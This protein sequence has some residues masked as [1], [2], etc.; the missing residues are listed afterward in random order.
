[1]T[2][3][4]NVTWSAPFQVNEISDPSWQKFL[5]REL[6][7]QY[8][9][10]LEKKLANDHKEMTKFTHFKFWPPRPLVFNAFNTTPWKK[11]KVVLLAQDPYFNPGQAMGLAFSH[12]RE[13]G[14]P[15]HSCLRN[16]YKELISDPAVEFDKMP[17][18]GD[19]T[20]WA[21]QGVLLLNTALSVREKSAGSH[22]GF[23][24][25]TFTDNAIKLLSKHHNHLVF[26]LWGGHAQEKAGLIDQSKH[27]VLETSH[28]SGL[29]CNKG[30]L[31]SR[32][33]SKCNKYLIKHGREAIRWNSLLKKMKNK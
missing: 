10:D 32:H 22:S 23:G 13:I 3:T 16:I 11:V 9:K 26:L 29:A 14:L 18:H 28:P 19:L 25:H 33:F 4:S 2:E 1:M 15:P 7:K 8:F 27:L 21:Q 20:S 30:F 5:A 31:G 17:E 12:P 6:K 24:W